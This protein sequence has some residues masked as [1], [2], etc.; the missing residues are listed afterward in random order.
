[1]VKGG[2]KYVPKEFIE[3]IEHIRTRDNIRN[4]SEIFKR[5]LDDYNV[6]KDIRNIINFNRRL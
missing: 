4:N 2:I 3:E 1:M 6:G 5:I